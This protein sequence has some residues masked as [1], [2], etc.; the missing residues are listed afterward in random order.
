M[1]FRRSVEVIAGDGIEWFCI[2]AA[3]LSAEKWPIKADL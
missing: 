2:H 3:L 1:I